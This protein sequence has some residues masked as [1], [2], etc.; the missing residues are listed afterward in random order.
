MAQLKKI[1]SVKGIGTMI[2]KDAISQQ[3]YEDI[4]R[5]IRNREINPGERLVIND[6]KKEY[7]VSSTPVRDAL[8]L[9]YRYGYVE[10]LGNARYAVISVTDQKV[11]DLLE[12]YWALQSISVEIT[13][14]HDKN[15]TYRYVKAAVEKFLACEEQNTY[16]SI[17]LYCDVLN[18]FADYNGNEC[19]SRLV[20][21]LLGIFAV[22]FGN[23]IDVFPHNTSVEICQELLLGFENNNK[24]TILH[25]LRRNVS[26]FYSYAEKHIFAKKIGTL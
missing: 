8:S 16:H 18:I 22:A 14:S 25:A 20:D 12:L 11:K 19:Y 17:R 23:Y 9:L 24:E 13:F 3:I 5:R 6:L 15:Y 1:S 2:V 26:C 4:D 7:D 21:P 10:N